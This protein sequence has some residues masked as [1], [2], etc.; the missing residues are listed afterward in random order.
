M[1]DS[2]SPTNV[3]SF[4]YINALVT[5]VSRLL[6]RGARQEAETCLE[7]LRNVAEPTSVW[8]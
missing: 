7:R 8:A 1:L 3:K 5:S 2:D 6:A 4:F